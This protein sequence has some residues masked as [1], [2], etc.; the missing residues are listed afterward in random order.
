MISTFGYS[1]SLDEVGVS[2]LG[3]AMETCGLKVICISWSTGS[4]GRWYIWA[5]GT[6]EQWEKF[7]SSEGSSEHLPARKKKSR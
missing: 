1:I 5:K 7:Y 6:A 4:V 3:A 2:R